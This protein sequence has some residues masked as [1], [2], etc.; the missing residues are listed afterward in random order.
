MRQWFDRDSEPDYERLKTRVGAFK[1]FYYDCEDQIQRT[2][3]TEK[4]FKSRVG[5][6]QAQLD[7]I[8]SIVGAHV[9]LGALAGSSQKRR[10]QKGVDILLAVDMMNHAIHQ[11]MRRAVLVSGDADF[12]PL[13]ESMVQIGMFVEIVGD[14]KRT[15][16]E[17]IRAADASELLA[18]DEY[19]TLAPTE[20]QNEFPLP[21]KRTIVY[22]KGYYEGRLVA[23]GQIGD[24]Q[25]LISHTDHR[26]NAFIPIADRQ[27]YVLSHSNF[28]R[29]KLYIQIQFPDV[30]IK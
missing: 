16:K 23:A 10:R 28:E 9:R 21:D 30:T 8:R 12:K 6:Q 26:Y 20:L 25:V 17:L 27:A 29:L 24:S 3:E 7:E 18:F 1:M 13:V 15:A 11:N 14:S 2:N 4:T 5:Q 19:F 22:Q